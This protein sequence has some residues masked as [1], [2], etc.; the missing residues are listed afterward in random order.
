[1]NPTT[2]RA[3]FVARRPYPLDAFQL[4][5]LD[6]LDRGE[7]VLVAAPTG[8]GKTLV[9]EYAVELA[10]AGGGKIFYT[11]PIKALSNQKFADLVREHGAERVGLLTGD[12]TINADAP[13]VVM[14]TEVLRNMIY[15]GAATLTDLRYVVLDEVHYLQNRF[16]GAV[17]EEVI[18]HL[19]PAVDLVCLSATVSNAEEF[20]DWIRTVR[21][22]TRAIIEER[23][24]VELTH[25]YAVG[26]R[27]ATDL[28]LL[29][30]YV[31]DGDEQHPNPEGARLDRHPRGHKGPRQR[32]SK[33]YAPYR[34]ELVE[35]L[36][37][38]AMLPAIYFIFSRN[39]CD[40]AVVQVRRDGL[41][42]TDADERTELR[43]IAERHTATLSD[44]DLDALG[45]DEWVAGLEAGFAAHHAGLVPP[46]KEAVEEAFGRGLVK[47]VFATETLGLGINMPAR[48]V[49]IEKLS[50]FTGEH[51]ELLTAGEYTQLA[52]RAGRR[53]IDEIGYAIVC[54]N[55]YVAFAQ[56]AALVGRR[57]YELT[58]S[59]R[60]TYNMAVNLVRRC[61][62]Q[63]AHELLNLS[64]AQY[65]ADRDVV[66]LERQVRRV[67]DQLARFRVT[68]ADA[69]GSLRSYR[70]LLAQRDAARVNAAQER[71]TRLEALRPGDVFD[72]GHGPVVVIKQDRG[73][74]PARVLVITGAGRVRRVGADEVSGFVERLGTLE[75]PRPFEPRSRE[76]ARAVADR[77][78]GARLAAP[79]AGGAT[80]LAQA[81]AALLDHPLA[82]DPALAVRLRAAVAAE[83]AAR[84]LT[85]L[86]RRVQSREESLARQLDR[87][88]GLLESWH[89]VRDWSLTPAG[90]LL[91]GL[92]TESDLLAAEAL[93]QGALDGL[94]SAAVA[95]VTSC[96]TFE[97]R[98]PDGDEPRPPRA[99]PSREVAQRCRRVERIW[100]DLA[101]A[102]RDA[103][104]PETRAPDPGFAAAAAGW[105][106]G[107]S[108][109]DL[110][111]DEEMTGGDFVRNVK[112][113]I[114]L[115]RQ[116]ALLAVNPATRQ[117]AADAADAC[118]RGVVEASSA[119][120][121]A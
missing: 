6:A 100:R 118:R 90:E 60:P 66:A 88:L 101:L 25:L 44:D 71:A 33:L 112:Q 108:L 12:N 29:P 83:R 75:L 103:Q 1:M 34:S 72:P 114:D 4:E 9:A 107:E 92:Y 76:F 87:V 67:N 65:H 82:G 61:T 94:D 24:P 91:T 2:V 69:D 84:D 41:R 53:G 78:G 8:S 17:W 89:Y 95:A 5:A 30:V 57:S 121:V 113:L 73:R 104:L 37:D 56:V 102:E 40:D 120:G 116:I 3:R 70:D 85:R 93:V 98:G 58:S 42:L 49:V 38:E 63:R 50:K 48:S 99:W 14:T 43:A 77:L 10:R 11:T 111:D 106:R 51:H 21:G 96:F 45:Y 23:R 110:L 81:E 62:P 15:A 20:A 18:I 109:S 105:V 47:V 86:Q 35:R 16:R 27:G 26:E 13:I 55:P 28:H 54:W 117:A 46:M 68:E 80:R 36:A 97:R 52:G 119:V 32:R 7:S 79:V 31:G 19:D 59:F 22:A 115:L 39:A 74:A 64:F